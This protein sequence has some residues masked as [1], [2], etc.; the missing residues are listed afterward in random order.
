MILPRPGVLAGRRGRRV[1][2][3]M[4]VGIVGAQSR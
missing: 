4:L 1:M 3:G 2:A